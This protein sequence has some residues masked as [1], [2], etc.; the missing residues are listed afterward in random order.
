VKKIQFFGWLLIAFCFLSSPIPNAFAQHSIPIEGGRAGQ[1][2]EFAEMV[3]ILESHLQLLIQDPNR[4]V[5]IR[6]FRG[7]DK[8]IVP[9]GNLSCRVLVPE[10]V[11]RGGYIT[12]TMIFY[13]NG[14]EIKKIRISAQADIFAEVISA[15]HFLRRHQEIQEEDVQ[16]VKKN[17]ALFPPDVVTKIEDILGKRTT[18]SVNSQEVLRL[19]MLE[20]PPLVNKGDRVIILFENDQFKITALG[21]AMEVGRKG[22]RVKLINLSSKREVYGRVLDASTVQVDF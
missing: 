4:K 19:S 18:L 3:K 21:E 8:V 17:L 22:D 20:I 15:R 7:Y 10:Q 11:V 14:Q 9:R 2:I 12:G 1:F 13:A 16:V 5:E 6:E